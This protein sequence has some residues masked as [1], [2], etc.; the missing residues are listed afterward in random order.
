MYLST[1]RYFSWTTVSPLNDNSLS[2]YLPSYISDG[3]DAEPNN[4]Y[5]APIP[6]Y[7]E[8]VALYLSSYS[9][10]SEYKG[11]KPNKQYGAPIE[12]LASYFSSAPSDYKAADPNN[13]YKAPIAE[14]KPS[15][16]KLE[17]GYKAPSSEPLATYETNFS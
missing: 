4:E 15:I 14:Y 9:A 2:G 11:A 7:E 10:P 12:E 3:K 5:R 8:P 16:T 1:L 17:D 6:K 13:E